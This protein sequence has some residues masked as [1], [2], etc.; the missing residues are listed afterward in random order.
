M[1]LK[2]TEATGMS[3]GTH[4]YYKTKR[5]PLEASFHRALSECGSL[6]VLDI[7]AGSGYFSDCL[8]ESGDRRIANMT[9]VDTGYA[10]ES[11]RT[12]PR[13][14]GMLTQTR[15][16]PE[17]IEDSYIL[18]MDVL[19]HV[20]DDAG[21][22]RSLISRCRGKNYFFITVPAFQSLWSA[23]DEFLGHHRRYTLVEVEALARQEGLNVGAGYYIYA[24]I[25][26][27]VWLLRRLRWNNGVSSSD[28]RPTSRI[29]SFVMETVC[30]LEFGLRR[31]NRVAG[32][33][34]V[35]E[36]RL[37]EEEKESRLRIKRAVSMAAEV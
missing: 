3:P 2:E 32:V 10:V 4:W 35:L 12:D 22:L 8:M 30:R 13:I 25:F 17:I 34:C 36:G 15:A 14:A 27:I 33:S 29:L 16:L 7:G 37:D 1:D 9:R 24:A 26:P 5:I 20:P 23:H 21:L 31:F 28:L 18:M 11:S 6:N 19:E